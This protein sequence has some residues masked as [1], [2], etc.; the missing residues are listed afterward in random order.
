MKKHGL[1]RGLHQGCG[2]S[3]CSVLFGDRYHVSIGVKKIDKA[4]KN[5]RARQ[6]GKQA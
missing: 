1:R 3:L 4:D 5:G 2:E 6:R